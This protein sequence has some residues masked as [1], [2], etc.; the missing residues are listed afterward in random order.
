MTDCP[1]VANIVVGPTAAGKSSVAQYIAE[2]KGALI[3]SADS[4]NIYRGM[5]IGTAK[6]S[7]AERQR[8]E[9]AGVDVVD[10]VEKCSVGDYLRFVSPSIRS[11]ASARRPVIIAGGT[12]LYVKCLTQGFDD[13]PAENPELRAR[14]QKMSVA[15][16]Q[17]ELRERDAARFDALA[18][19]LNPRRLIR[20][21]EMAEQ[22]APLPQSWNSE[23]IPVVGLRWPRELL[24]RRIEKRVDQMYAEGLLDEARGLAGLELSPTAMAGIGYAEAF[25]VLCGK[26]TEAA[27]KERTVIRTRQLAKRQMTWFRNQLDV[28]WVDI[29]DENPDI[30]EIAA[31]VQAIWTE[32]GPVPLKI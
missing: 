8:A 22:G 20:A 1:L 5:D 14:L 32:L 16:L 27:A 18:D 9:Y 19:Q 24:L 25:A 12:G 21:I 30:A 26:M 23:K 15:E 3:V 17:G 31:R 7:D 10:P 28:R 6:A 4:M 11:A 2:T 13:L 29:E